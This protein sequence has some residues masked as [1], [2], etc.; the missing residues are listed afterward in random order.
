MLSLSVAK[1]TTSYTR[2][3]KYNE[4]KNENIVHKNLCLFN[5]NKQQCKQ[6]LYFIL[7][8]LVL[9]SF[10]AWFTLT[11]FAPIVVIPVA[12]IYSL[13]CWLCCFFKSFFS[14]FDVQISPANNDISIN[15]EKPQSMHFKLVILK[16]LMVLLNEI[17]SSL[18]WWLTSM[19]KK[20]RTKR[21]SNF[22]K[23][24]S[25]SQTTITTSY[26]EFKATDSKRR[27]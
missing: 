12:T 15:V 11:L 1:T 21:A 2:W 9:L 3:W 26:C 10:A 23:L 7:S 19:H 14:C 5:L 22:L 27:Q 24:S 18:C 4:K 25:S 20:S 16:S 8:G 6:C 17:S 13:F